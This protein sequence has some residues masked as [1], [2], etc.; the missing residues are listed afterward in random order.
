MKSEE[1]VYVVSVLKQ[2]FRFQVDVLKKTNNR[3]LEIFIHFTADLSLRSRYYLIIVLNSQDQV[4]HSVYRYF[5]RFQ[6]KLS[7]HCKDVLS[8]RRKSKM[9]CEIVA[10]LDE[11]QQEDDVGAAVA[12]EVYEVGVWLKLQADVKTDVDYR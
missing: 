4:T 12:Y 8:M 10:K 7:D 2:R 3:V 1:F 11:S 6:L 9:I 5:V